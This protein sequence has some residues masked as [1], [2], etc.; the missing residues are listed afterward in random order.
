MS[1]K[2]PLYDWHIQNKGR[3]IDFAGWFLPVDYPAGILKEHLTCRKFG[4]LFDICHM[5]R[6]V[7]RGDQAEQF[8]NQ[9]LT[10]DASRLS[11]G[12]AQYTI[13]ATDEGRAVD[14]AFLYQFR[15]GEYLLVVNASNK[16]KDWAWLRDRLITGAELT[17]VSR[18]LGMIAIQGP[19]SEKV[20][21]GLTSD[22]LPPAGRNH[23]GIISLAGV[24]VLISR[25]GYTG[26][27]IAFELCV[28]WEKTVQVW[29]ELLSAGAP[30]GLIPIGLGARDTLRLEASLPLYVHELSD[31]MPIMALPQARFAVNLKNGRGDFIGRKALA[32]QIE[33]L[34]TDQTKLVSRKIMSVA[35]TVRSMI[36]D[37]S[38][39]LADHRLVG[40]LT[41]ATMTP[42]WQFNNS[43]PG[44]ES[45]TRAL[46]LAY[47]DRSLKPGQEVEIIYRNKKIPGVIV[48]SH[49]TATGSY[50]QPLMPKA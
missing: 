19:V 42:A 33:E 29:T 16:D 5:G 22:P 47:L 15:E 12:R 24:E 32:A 6:F 13:I 36:R 18:K 37:G 46:G 31:E 10:N 34:K 25:T 38:E 1:D 3:V 21:A 39:V 7:I 8:L 44:E 14:D 26:E 30:E 35:A 28:P 27:K 11:P 20:V 23:V 49:V 48:A 43:H 50:I 17:D 41:S 45:Y 40:R 9:T 4:G 2:T